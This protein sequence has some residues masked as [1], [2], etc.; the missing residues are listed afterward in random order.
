M[1]KITVL[2][3]FVLSLICLVS[4]ATG[5]VTNSSEQ[6]PLT[7]TQKSQSTSGLL[8]GTV[9]FGAG[10]FFPTSNDIIDIS[11]LKTDG[12]TGLITEI[13]HSRI[14]RP[15]NFPIQFSMSYDTADVSEGDT[16]TLIVTLLVGDEITR[17]GM[18]LLTRTENGFADASL[19]LLGI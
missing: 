6:F 15:P 2:L 7:Q 8:R 19:T 14:R 3:I 4:C 18:T 10:Y 13:S 1:R 9:N 17:Q 12:T 11:M 5:P 16:C